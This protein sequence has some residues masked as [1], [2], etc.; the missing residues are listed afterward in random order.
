MIS[1][2]KAEHTFH[3]DATMKH[4]GKNLRDQNEMES[5]PKI[6]DEKFKKATR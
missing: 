6:G 3:N 2:I 5:L 4:F 1:L